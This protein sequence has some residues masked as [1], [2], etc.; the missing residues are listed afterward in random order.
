MFS[1]IVRCCCQFLRILVLDI[2]GRVVKSRSYRLLS[3]VATLVEH[4]WALLELSG[5]LYSLLGFLWSVGALY[6]PLQLGLCIVCSLFVF[7]V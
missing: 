2:K 3:L 6:G 4:L 5:T 7:F 1:C